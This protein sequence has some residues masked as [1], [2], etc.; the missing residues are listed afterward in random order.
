MSLILWVLFL[1]IVLVVVRLA[2]API[3][4]GCTMKTLFFPGVLVAIASKTL[5]CFLTKS[6]LKSVNFPWRPG[7]PVIHEPSPVKM[8]GIAVTSCATVV[9]GVWLVLYLRGL[10]HPAF[11]GLNALPAI[12]ADGTTIGTWWDTSMGVLS[13]VPSLFDQ[14][15]QSGWSVFLFL[16]LAIS[17]QTYTAPSPREWKVIAIVLVLLALPIA[18]IDWLGLQAGF[19]SRGWF[20]RRSYGPMVFEALAVLVSCAWITLV[21]AGSARFVYAFLK[22]ALAPSD[23]GAK[24]EKAHAH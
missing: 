4:C 16:Y 23:Q 18:G 14:L 19:F 10:L 7:E 5:A 15:R 6:K 2:V 12:E 11:C 3:Y 24:R 22:A 8:V 20:I 17:I 21:I 13:N 1:T 9:T